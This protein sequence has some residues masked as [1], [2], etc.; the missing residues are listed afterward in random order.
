MNQ[1]KIDNRGGAQKSGESVTD[2]IAKKTADREMLNVFQ[3]N[4]LR[5]LCPQLAWDGVIDQQLG[6]F[7]R[8]H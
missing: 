5:L 3:Q 4:R 1:I 7:P 6:S 8:R 2:K